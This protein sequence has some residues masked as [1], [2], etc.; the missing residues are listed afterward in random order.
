MDYGFKG[1][2]EVK[3]TW[4]DHLPVHVSTRAAKGHTRYVTIPKGESIF[5]DETELTDQILTL[6][7][8]GAVKLNYHE[9]IRLEKLKQL[10]LPTKLRA[11]FVNTQSLDKDSDTRESVVV[12]EDAPIMLSCPSCSKEFKSKKRFQTHVE[13][14]TVSEE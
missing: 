3:N 6:E 9:R 14:H 12:I 5:L 1:T 2:V 13:S 7:K 11:T 8:R 4:D 10:A